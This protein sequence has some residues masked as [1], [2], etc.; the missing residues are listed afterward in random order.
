MRQFLRTILKP[1]RVLWQFLAT[2]A[3]L[4]RGLFAYARTGR[5]P[6]RAYHSLISLYCRTSGYS[7]DVLHAAVRLTRRPRRFPH[8]NGILGDL[9]SDDVRRA[10]DAIREHGYYVFPKRMEP[11]LCD[12]LTEFALSQ[13]ARLTPPRESVALRAVYDREHPVA[14]GYKFEDELLVRNADIQALMADFSLLE[15]AQA[16]L[17]CLPMLNLVALWWS[18]SARFSDVAQTELAQL[19]HFDMDSIKWIKFFFYLTDV[20]SDTGAHCFVARS[21][22]SGRQPLELLNRGYARI[23]DDELAPYFSEDSIIEMTGPRGT[24]LAEDTRGLHKGKPPIRDD[25][26]L[27]QIEFSDCLFGP[28][29]SIPRLHADEIAALPPAIREY[30]RIYSRLQ[31]DANEMV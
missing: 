7:N 15:V 25:R 9:S 19:Y 30:P 6:E 3:T 14:E 28:V 2:A 21:H 11:E 26:L 5:T 24:I 31:M 22:R 4:I 18:T 8:A 1:V 23:N 13:P 29:Y 20:T 16:Y 17:G 12:K 10:A 27:L